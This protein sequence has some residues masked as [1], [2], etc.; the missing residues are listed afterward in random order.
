[1]LNV[2]RYRFL[3]IHRD[4]SVDNSNS[5]IGRDFGSLLFSLMQQYSVKLGVVYLIGGPSGISLPTQ[6]FLKYLPWVLVSLTF[7]THDLYQLSLQHQPMLS[8]AM[9]SEAGQRVPM[10]GQIVRGN[11]SLLPPQINPNDMHCLS[12]T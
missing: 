9:V 3:I 10:A 12:S 5:R 6:I 11:C 4:R 1:M 2:D 8:H 7:Q